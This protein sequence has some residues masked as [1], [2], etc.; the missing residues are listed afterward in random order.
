MTR[1]RGVTDLDQKAQAVA[2]ILQPIESEVGEDRSCSPMVS[3]RSEFLDCQ[4]PG[5]M[6]R[7][8]RRSGD[9]SVSLVLPESSWS[10]GSTVPSRDDPWVPYRVRDPRISSES[11][12]RN[13]GLLPYSTWIKSRSASPD[14]P[15]S[16]RVSRSARGRGVAPSRADT[17]QRS[18]R[19]TRER[20]RH[21]FRVDAS[22]AQR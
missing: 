13:R 14:G 8:P 17:A 9:L 3:G 19:S 6:T 4:D 16:R 22:D 2:G 10:R 21:R 20:A 11:T 12:S 15:G 7:R 18:R 1:L 5:R